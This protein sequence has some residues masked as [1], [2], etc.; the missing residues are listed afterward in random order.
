MLAEERFQ[1]LIL[2]RDKEET[3]EGFDGT[4]PTEYL[5]H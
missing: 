5:S 3:I 1:L 2:M 4:Q